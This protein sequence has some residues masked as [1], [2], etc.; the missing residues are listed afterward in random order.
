M[1]QTFNNRALQ[2]DQ[3]ENENNRKTESQQSAHEES[4]E[5]YEK[6]IKIKIL[7]ASLKFVPDMGWSKQAISAGAETIGYPGVVHGLFP[8][9]GADLVHYFYSTCNRQLNQIL[10]KEALEM[11][12]TSVPRK[13]EEQVR[14]ALEKRLRMVIP[15]KKTWPQAMAIMTLPPNVPVSLANLL[16]L[17]DDICYYAGDRS[18]D[19]NWYTRRMILAIIYKATE[20]YMLQDT[21][22]DHKETWLFLERRI[23]DALQMYKVLFNSGLSSDS[24]L[25]LFGETGAAAFVTARNIL[26]MNCFRNNRRF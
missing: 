13:P 15:Y 8:N 10:E 16:T 3:F 21:S 6:N 25:K 19:F 9:G 23:K 4:D 22:E 14:D 7:G 26:G 11:A 17:I 12:S 20:L 18:V 5:E 2:A 1:G 24:T